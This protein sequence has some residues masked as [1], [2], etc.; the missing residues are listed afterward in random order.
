MLK[1]PASFVLARHCHLTIS[2]AFTHVTRFIQR[3]VNLRGSPYRK[4]TP[5]ILELWDMTP[6]GCDR[7]IRLRS[8]ETMAEPGRHSPPSTSPNSCRGPRA[9]IRTRTGFTKE[10][11]MQPSSVC[12]GIDISKAQLDIVVASGGESHGAL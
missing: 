9:R 4:G 1:K 10:A 5:C 2:A 3:V 11:A 7:S 8:K 6:T 12:V